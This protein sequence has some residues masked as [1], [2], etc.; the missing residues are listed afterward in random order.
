MLK[1][2]RI[3]GVGMT[4]MGRFGRTA[5]DLSSEA[6]RLALT[7][8][9]IGLTD[10]HGLVAVPSLSQPHFMQAHYLAT[11]MKLLPSKRF[12]V[13][14][15]DTG[16]AGPISAI[17]T[18]ATLIRQDWADVVAIVAGDAVLSLPSDEFLKRAD[19]SVEG[20]GQLQ[21][22]CIPNGYDRIAQWHLKAHPSLRRE[23]LAMVPVIESHLAAKHPYAMSRKPLTLEDVLRSRPV[24]AVTNLLECARRADGACAIILS[25]AKHFKR[26][27]AKPL[28]DCPVVISTG[29][30]SGPLFP[31]PI[32]QITEDLFSCEQA[33]KRAYE[34]AQL[35][36][37]DIDFF[38]LYDCFPIC[39]IRALEATKLCGVDEGGAFVEEVYKRLLRTGSVDTTLWPVNTHGGLQC[40]G[41]PWEVPAM[42]NVIEAVAQLT[43]T[44][45]DRQLR[46]LKKKPKRALVYGNG[47]IF[48][49]SSVAILGD[50][51]YDGVRDN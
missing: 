29:E 51:V 41:A 42:Y 27:Y 3:V 1:Q 23:H 30:A 18:A 38:G 21:S 32:E 31:P 14:T 12:V 10:L 37:S 5:E 49:A 26:H 13:R 50:G 7:D 24:G 35:S 28:T 48:S 36:A 43:G 46:G 39:L 8:A 16:G 25:S 22:P 33:T 47:G 44:A 45:G 19:M 9:G 4:K 15:I 20:D 40:F 34:A 6:I 17:N 11:K 2:V